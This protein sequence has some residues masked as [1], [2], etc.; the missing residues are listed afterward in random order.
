[1]SGES[2]LIVLLVLCVI[3]L[4]VLLIFR[5]QR[6]KRQSVMIQN[7]ASSELS[8][9]M[10]KN[11]K[12][13]AIVTVARI[14]SD[15]LKDRCNCEYIVFLRKKR[16]LL[17]LNYYH[18][19]RGFN[20][21]DFRID[22]KK[23]LLEILRNDYFPRDLSVIKQFLSPIFLKKTE[24][25]KMDQFFPVYW[26]DN[27]YGLYVIKSN[28]D[29]RSPAFKSL[30]A[31][32]TQSL[33]AAY[34]IKWHESKLENLQEKVDT[35][36]TIR[37]ASLEAG[38]QSDKILKLIRHRKTETIIPKLISIL[39]ESAQIEKLTFFYNS[40]DQ[41]GDLL[42]ICDDSSELIDPP[43]KKTLQQLLH[44]LKSKDFIDVS[45]LVKNGEPENPWVTK[46][47]TKGVK[48]AAS[49][50]L[51]KQQDGL[52]VWKQIGNPKQI[53]EQINQH[54]NFTTALI[55]NAIE[56]EK[57]EEMSYTDNLTK[58]SNHRYFHKRLE[59]EINRAMRYD[60]KLALIIFDI[61]ELKPVND[62]YGH[63]AGDAIIRQMGS[64]LKKSIRAIDVVSRYGGDE[65][66]IIMPEADEATCLQ[67]IERLRNKIIS[68]SFSIDG[69][70]ES[71]NCTISMGAAI[72]P[73][74]AKN[75]NKL[76]Y[77][78][79]MALLEAKETG[80]NRSLV[81]TRTYL[82]E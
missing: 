65:F 49:F 3:F 82:S 74:H 52:L 56:Y 7:I 43:D 69:Y 41:N 23:D 76:I 12:E 79:D 8:D 5:I 16:G 48:Y 67:F 70:N 37:S 11:A 60:R 32:L 15:I 72:Y 6:E 57:I 42:R 68:S 71:I 39:K 45:L 47:I 18:G 28:R 58:L 66:C 78:A 17:E 73:I 81:S 4:S 20:R 31:Q 29:T 38:Q 63:Q 21:T 14:F 75:A 35:S 51:T 55:E 62:T 30:I 53:I 33:S 1:M 40:K 25:F 2:A 19:I 27:L 22:Y 34:H 26:R 9:F 50:P 36:S 61:D 44:S 10:S 59:E 64:I 54:R 80:R 77:A 13:G 24:E 46:L